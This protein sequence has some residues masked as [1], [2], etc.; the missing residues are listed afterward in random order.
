[1]AYCLAW[2]AAMLV[3]WVGIRLI[4]KIDQDS[5]MFMSKFIS[6]THI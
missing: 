2:D 5:F 1:M 4:Q 6:L 3:T